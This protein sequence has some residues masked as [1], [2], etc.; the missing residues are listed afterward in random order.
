M[1]NPAR[2]NLILAQLPRMV[3]I[4]REGNCLPFGKETDGGAMCFDCDHSDQKTCDF[5]IPCWQ[6]PKL[7]LRYHHD[8]CRA[9]GL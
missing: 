2:G 4:L 7:V 3:N 5:W 8:R 1:E 6:E 9:V